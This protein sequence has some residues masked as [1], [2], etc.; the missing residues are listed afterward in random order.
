KHEV[1]VIVVTGKIGE[2]IEGLYD[3][4]V[5][6]VYSIVNRPMALKGAMDQAPGLIQDC[7]KNIMLTIKCF[8]KS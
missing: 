1:P 3:I 5:S 4:G 8:N 2:G 6:A 7:A